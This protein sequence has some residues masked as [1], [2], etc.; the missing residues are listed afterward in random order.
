MPWGLNPPAGHPILSLRLDGAM[1]AMVVREAS[2]RRGSVGGSGGGKKGKVGGGRSSGHRGGDLGRAPGV[3]R[4]TSSSTTRSSSFSRKRS[5]APSG[6]SYYSGR[7]GQG[8]MTEGAITVTVASIRAEGSDAGVDKSRGVML[9]ILAVFPKVVRRGSSNGSS[10]S[11]SGSGS[12]ANNV[13]RGDASVRVDDDVVP[14]PNTNTSP[15][16][17]FAADIGKA[18][19]SVGDRA[20]GAAG[21]ASR[22]DRGDGFP[23]AAPP[24][25]AQPPARAGSS[26]SPPA[27]GSGLEIA[28]KWTLEPLHSGSGGGGG[29][30]GGSGFPTATG[31]RRCRSSNAGSSGTSGH[32]P[33]QP[34]FVPMQRPAV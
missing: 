15:D 2:G 8:G 6:A 29:G 14:A 11:S 32:K 26:C 7:E 30:G 4:E 10:S 16:N 21:G 12:G 33:T 5:G 17:S 3:S 18:S 13:T 1:L 22:G 9:P 23:S 31:P 34:F 25:L 20:G 19:S 28:S 24:F 27:S